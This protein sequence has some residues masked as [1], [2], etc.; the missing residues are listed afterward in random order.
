MNARDETEDDA[1]RRVRDL[2]VILFYLTRWTEKPRPKLPLGVEVPWRAWK[3][4]DWEALDRLKEEG[5]IGFT[6]RV[7]SVGLTDTGEREAQRL[8]ERYGFRSR[9]DEER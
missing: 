6:Y 8:L 5:L 1:R 3:G 7:K 9:D 2:T 4:Q